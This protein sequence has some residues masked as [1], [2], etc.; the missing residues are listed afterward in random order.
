MQTPAVVS[1][2]AVLHLFEDR[3]AVLE[4]RATPSSSNDQSKASEFA[5]AAAPVDLAPKGDKLGNPFARC[6]R[7][8]LQSDKP[9]VPSE[10]YGRLKQSRFQTTRLI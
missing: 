2:G 3:Q 8:G 7:L 10:L 5:T 1:V 9:F 6:F 4:E